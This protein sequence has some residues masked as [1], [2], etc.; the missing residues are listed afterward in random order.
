M[1]RD[2]ST[3]E[4]KTPTEYKNEQSMFGKIQ[5]MITPNITTGKGGRKK[6]NKRRKQKTK[7]NRKRKTNRKYKSKK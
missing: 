3:T 2:S 6:T 5:S 4:D 1:E 7:R